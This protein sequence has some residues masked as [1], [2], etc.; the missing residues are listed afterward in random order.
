MLVVPVVVVVAVAVD[1]VPN[2]ENSRDVEMSEYNDPTGEEATSIPPLGVEMNPKKS[3]VV[4]VA[5]VAVV[6][7]DDDDDE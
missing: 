1:A 6:V 7:D 3:W 4:V 2:D 5:V